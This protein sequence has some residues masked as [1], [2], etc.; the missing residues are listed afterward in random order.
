[1]RQQG[2]LDR[3]HDDRRLETVPAQDAHS[4]SDLPDIDGRAPA[5]GWYRGRRFCRKSGPTTRESLR[6]RS[7]RDEEEEEDDDHEADEDRDPAVIREP[8]EDE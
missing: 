6:T 8:D 2:P 1:M 7:R 4:H 3:E 5:S